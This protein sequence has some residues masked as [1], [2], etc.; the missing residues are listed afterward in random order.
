MDGRK[1]YAKSDQLYARPYKKL[2]LWYAKKVRNVT[3]DDRY[4]REEK[5]YCLEGTNVGE[6]YTSE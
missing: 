4:D 2:F 1:L 5:D 6:V 3:K